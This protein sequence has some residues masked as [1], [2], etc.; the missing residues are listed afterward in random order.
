MHNFTEFFRKYSRLILFV[1]L[2]G[3]SLFFIYKNNKYQRVLIFNAANET[4]GSAFEI[5]ADGREY[6][7]M[8]KTNRLLAEENAALR[9]Q[10]LSD[11]YK[12]YNKWMN[13][14]TT[15]KQMYTYIPA[16]IINN[17]VDKANNRITLNVGSLH[18]VEAGM[19]VISPDGVVGVITTVS[20]HFS[21][22]L[23]LLSK[24]K[25]SARLRG[26]SFGT[27]SWQDTDENTLTLDRIP[28]YVN[29]TPGDTVE[30]SNFS[31]IFPEGIPIGRVKSFNLD[32]D[33]G[34]FRIK[35]KPSNEFRN[36]GAVY[37]V[38][39]MFKRE[40]LMLEDSASVGDPKE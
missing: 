27:L 26:S 17:S 22:G 4:A 33:E 6:L 34:Y 29:V 31:T 8:K 20:S 2:L 12:I 5:Y 15:Y 3:I 39:Y 21:V 36:L 7:S 30:T 37:V 24:W 16:Q 11:K 10:L 1:L 25:V 35:V 38:D 23:S 13:S 32:A 14:D 40:Q 19:G 9:A 18:G 28:S